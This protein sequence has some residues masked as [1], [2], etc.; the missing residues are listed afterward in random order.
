MNTFTEFNTV[1][2]TIL[3]AIAQHNGILVSRQLF[4]VG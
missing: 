1:E 4:N 2:Q 3:N